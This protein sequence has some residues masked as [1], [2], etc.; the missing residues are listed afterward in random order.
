MAN[1]TI[2]NTLLAAIV[3]AV[4]CVGTV[5]ARQLRSDANGFAT[6]GGSC[7][8]NKPCKSGCICAF[9]LESTTGFCSTHPTGVQPPA[10]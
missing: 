2:K 4:L 6:C 9:P 7:G 8:A 1:K 3:T 10:K 5:S